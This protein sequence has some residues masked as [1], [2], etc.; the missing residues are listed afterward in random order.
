MPMQYFIGIFILNFM[1]S[2]AIATPHI[3]TLRARHYRSSPQRAFLNR[4]YPASLELLSLIT[5]NF[6]HEK[7]MI[8][9]D[10]NRLIYDLATLIL[11][12]DQKQKITFLSTQFLE[13]ESSTLAQE[14]NIGN[15]KTILISSPNTREFYLKI[16]SLTPRQYRNKLI[17]IQ[18]GSHLEGEIES[19]LFMMRLNH[20]ATRLNAQFYPLILFEYEQLYNRTDFSRIRADLLAYTQR[21]STR[22]LF[23]YMQES[24]Q[25]ITQYEHTNNSDNLADFALIYQQLRESDPF[26]A[27]AMIRDY[28]RL[29]PIIYQKRALNLQHLGLSALLRTQNL[30]HH[31]NIDDEFPMV[32]NLIEE[33]RPYR[34]STSDDNFFVGLIRQKRFTELAFSLLLFNEE[35]IHVHFVNALAQ[36]EIDTKL[37]EFLLLYINNH[38]NMSFLNQMA[39]QFFTPQRVLSQRALLRECI[40]RVD[41]HHLSN[42]ITF[43]LARNPSEFQAEISS[44]QTRAQP[45]PALRYQLDQLNIQIANANCTDLLS[46]L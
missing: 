36:I 11:N 41:D 26:R 22:E 16:R 39:I 31:L 5:T 35:W 43:V 12:E 13:Q 42:Y 17:P 1:V 46:K 37:H 34:S 10:Q 45:N 27:E 40:Q 15:Q 7:V 25:L 2:F 4:L 29:R 20:V 38:P 44:L 3:D 19:R 30:N 14:L 6:S 18:L 32:R 9:G 24:W 23:S 33:M 28:N 8:L 21:E